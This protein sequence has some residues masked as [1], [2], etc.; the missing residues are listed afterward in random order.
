MHFAHHPLRA[1]ED[2]IRRHPRFAREVGPVLPA[3][4]QR[5]ESSSKRSENKRGVLGVIAHGG[6]SIGFLRQTV[7]T[8]RQDRLRLLCCERARAVYLDSRQRLMGPPHTHTHTGNCAAPR[9]R[10]PACAPKHM[11]SA[12][13]NAPKQRRKRGVDDTNDSR[14]WGQRNKPPGDTSLHTCLKQGG[15]EVREGHR[16]ERG[17]AVR[18]AEAFARLQQQGEHLG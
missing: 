12:D 8:A 16:R 5:L 17:V 7:N 11:T 13:A 18:G 10:T 1:H 2:S 3:R 6:D 4:Q 14:L 9:Q 15:V